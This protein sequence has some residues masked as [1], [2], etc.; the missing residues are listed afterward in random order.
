[1]SVGFSGGYTFGFNGQMKDDEVYGEGN[2]YAFEY[3]IHDA[4]LGRFLSVDPLAPEYPFNS[5]YAFAQNCV[6]SGGDLE[7]REHELRIN[8]GA[9]AEKVKSALKT[10]DANLIFNSVYNIHSNSTVYNTS[11]GKREPITYNYNPLNSHVLLAIFDNDNKKLFNI[12][13]VKPGEKNDNKGG[14]MLTGEKGG[15]IKAPI[16]LPSRSINIDHV[17]ILAGLKTPDVHPIADALDLM[18][19]LYELFDILKPEQSKEIQSSPPNNTLEK[20]EEIKEIQIVNDITNKHIGTIT[21]IEGDPDTIRLDK[22]TSIKKEV[23]NI[24]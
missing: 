10:Q 8:W 23:R 7:G 2:A 18:Y 15:P 21:G 3:R 19:Q 22:M 6:I 24:K 9:D 16:G 14:F 12:L 1:M 17:L 5:T 13:Y 4:R 20:G 11:N